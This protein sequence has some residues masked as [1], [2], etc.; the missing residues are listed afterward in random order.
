MAAAV[1]YEVNSSTRE[2]SGAADHIWIKR[3]VGMICA[4]SRQNSSRPQKEEYEVDS[5]DVVSRGGSR[6]KANFLR[7]GSRPK[8]PKPV[9]SI[10]WRVKDS[11]L[12]SLA[13]KLEIAARKVSEPDWLQIEISTFFTLGYLHPKAERREMW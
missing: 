1:G 3:T 5:M 12:V 6:C 4:S 8:C 10:S 7:V 11:M 2:T 9:R 13:R